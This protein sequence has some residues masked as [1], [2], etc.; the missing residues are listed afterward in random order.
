MKKLLPIIIIIGVIL[1]YL[2]SKQQNPVSTSPSPT[3]R[4]DNVTVT[5]E[6]VEEKSTPIK[7]G[8][9]NKLLVFKIVLDTHSV[10]LNA[11]DLENN[12]NIIKNGQNIKPQQVNTSGSIHHKTAE[13]VFNSTPTP[14]TIV[15]TNLDNEQE[16]K[17][18]FTF[19]N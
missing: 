1:I 12:I 11:F 19:L 7:S 6:F 4:S 18:E 10:D 16:R 9:T 17:F 14:F 5:V 8:S 2:Q 15:V 3:S 13:V